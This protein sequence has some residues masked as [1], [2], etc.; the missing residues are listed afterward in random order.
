MTCNS[1]VQQFWLYKKHPG[2]TLL[3]C[4]RRPTCA[5]FMQNV[6]PSCTRIWSWRTASEVKGIKKYV[7][8]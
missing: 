6:S 1:K 7:E 8:I 5:P 2:L 4:M 3:A